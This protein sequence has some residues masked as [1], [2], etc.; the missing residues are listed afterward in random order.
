MKHS[1]DERISLLRRRPDAVRLE[2]EGLAEVLKRPRDGL[3]PHP[4]TL[5]ARA[6]SLVLLSLRLALLCSGGSHLRVTLG[7]CSFGAGDEPLDEEGVA[8]ERLLVGEV[9][10]RVVRRLRARRVVDLGLE[11]GQEGVDQ[12]GLDGCRRRGLVSESKT[13]QRSVSCLCTLN[14]G[15]WKHRT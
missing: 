4:V 6:S 8:L 1:L 13:Q 10:G 5:L 14:T 3:L 15:N 7:R 9:R 12:L 2:L 11:G